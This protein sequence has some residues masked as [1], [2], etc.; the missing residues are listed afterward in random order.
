MKHN[1][2]DMSSF[3]SFYIWW[4]TPISCLGITG[5]TSECLLRTM[6]RVMNQFVQRPSGVCTVCMPK[7]Y[8]RLPPSCRWRDGT[9]R[10]VRSMSSPN[11]LCPFTGPEG[12]SCDG[13]GSFFPSLTIRMVSSPDAV[14]GDPET[15]RPDQVSVRGL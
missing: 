1:A 7:V 12:T 3:L 6:P 15:L 9:R 8:M 14:V 10:V 4:I 13:M 2:R 5:R 11:N